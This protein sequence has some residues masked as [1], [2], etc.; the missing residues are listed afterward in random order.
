MSFS[1]TYEI[2]FDNGVNWTDITR[3]VNSRQTRITYPAMSGEY[4]SSVGQLSFQLSYKKNKGQLPDHAALFASLVAAKIAN[5]KVY[6]HLLQSN[7]AIFTGTLDLASLSQDI[8]NKPEWVQVSV[9]DNIRLLDENMENEFEFPGDPFAFRDKDGNIVVYHSSDGKWYYK[10]STIEYKGTRYPIYDPE[11]LWP[12]FKCDA[13][14]TE[15]DLVTQIF[16]AQGW[17]LSDINFAL[18]EPIYAS[19]GQSWRKSYAS[20]DPT[21][22]SGRRTLRDYLDSLL[23]ESLAYLT[24]DGDGKFVIRRFKMTASKLANT[25]GIAHYLKNTRSLNIGGAPWNKDGIKLTW[26]TPAAMKAKVYDASFAASISYGKDAEGNETDEL[27]QGGYDMPGHTYWPETGDMEEVWFDFSSDWLDRQYLCKITSKRDEDMTLITTKN[28]VIDAQREPDIVLAEL[29]GGE[30]DNPTIKPLRM[31]TLFYNNSSAA[32]KF[33][34]YKVYADC[35][36]RAKVNTMACPESAKDYDEY[37]SQFIF[38]EENATE[39][40]R[41]MYNF[42]HY[43]SMVYKWVQKAEAKPGEIWVVAPIDTDISTKAFVTQVEVSFENGTAWYT[44]TAMGVSEYNSEDVRR[45]S[46]SVGAT[47]AN[48]GEKGDATI[49]RNGTALWGESTARGAAGNLNDYYLNTETFNLYRCIQAGNSSTAVWQYVGTIKGNDATIDGVKF[50]IEYALST[51]PEIVQFDGLYGTGSNGVYGVGSDGVFG[52]YNDV[53]SGEVKDWHKGLYV[54][55]RIKTI[56]EDGIVSYKDPVYCEDMTKALV[57]ACVFELDPSSAEF[58]KNLACPNSTTDDYTVTLR[59]NG[60]SESDASNPLYSWTI[61]SNGLDVAAISSITASG[62]T[63]SFTLRRNTDATEITIE[64]VGIHDESI[65]IDPDATDAQKAKAIS[66]CIEKASV[67][68]TAN[69]IT[70]FGVYGGVFANDA[71]ADAYFLQECGGVYQGYSY[72]RCDINNPIYSDI[73]IRY[74]GVDGQWNNLLI[75]TNGAGQILSQCEKDFWSLYDNTTDENKEYLWNTY[76]Y[77]K[78][79]IAHAIATSKIVL[80][81]ASNGESGVIASANIPTDVTQGLDSQGKYLRENGFRLEG[82][83]GI[84]RA[85]SGYFNNISIGADSVFDGEIHANAVET[86]NG[87]TNTNTYS[88]NNS[89]NTP[90]WSYNE[91][92]NLLPATSIVEDFD[93]NNS[94]LNGHLLTKYCHMTDLSQIYAG[95]DWNEY[96]VL[97]NDTGE[98]MHTHTYKVKGNA[99]NGIR[100]TVVRPFTKTYLVITYAYRV[101]EARIYLNDELIYTKPFAGYINKDG[102]WAVNQ[103]SYDI[104]NAVKG[105]TIKVEINGIENVAGYDVEGVAIRHFPTLTYTYNIN[106]VGIWLYDSVDARWI[107]MPQTSYQSTSL[108]AQLN[109]SQVIRKYYTWENDCERSGVLIVNGAI[110]SITDAVLVRDG[111]AYSQ[112]LVSV[113]WNENGITFIDVNDNYETISKGSFYLSFSFTFRGSASDSY[114]KLENVLP[115]RDGVTELGEPGKEFNNGYFLNFNFRGNNVE[116]A[117]IEFSFSDSDPDNIWWYRK[118]NDGFIEQG[119]LLNGSIT[120][121]TDSSKPIHNYT[122]SHPFADDVIQVFAMVGYPNYTGDSVSNPDP[123]SNSYQIFPYKVTKTSVNFGWVNDVTEYDNVTRPF[124]WYA[125]GY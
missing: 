98:Q 1:F 76:G 75:S 67:T 3:F 7:T 124:Y 48:Q 78:E 115:M 104:N 60:F 12:V 55:Q 77:K 97:N 37:T 26:A 8:G 40:V 117:V 34:R 54:W 66:G 62:D 90:Y 25:K 87:N 51:S 31:R 57:D 83:N 56:N 64:V 89:G 88:G 108:V 29:D 27:V 41:G 30:T 42:R 11:K 86:H 109:G 43:G 65:L 45:T 4:K 85:T 28:V 33:T 22:S 6:F 71:D 119:G 107:L 2:S 120:T 74:F 99:S 21:G 9:Y 24:T 103:F 102:A 114:V 121:R 36:Y 47:E 18:S 38:S 125:C 95:D 106:K 44:V 32:R 46:Y 91:L 122:F 52:F 80:Y 19:D 61:N 73:V 123:M 10:D 59:F 35:L 13:E 15:N 63:I 79:I 82:K 113:S 92:S 100:V 49:W 20:Y 70:R 118:W 81:D 5:E 101:P 116:R 111:T 53:W 16:L 93:N 39:Y 94:Q 17:E 110:G 14:D 112:Q 68:M 84:I 50:I 58:V 23:H 96:T 72:I 105:D 69:D